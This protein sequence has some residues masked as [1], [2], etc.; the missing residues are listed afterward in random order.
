MWYCD[1]EQL[2]GWGCALFRMPNLEL[3]D[4]GGGREPFLRPEAG[5][6]A[7]DRE[8]QVVCLL[9]SHRLTRH[10]LSHTCTRATPTE[11]FARGKYFGISIDN[12]ADSAQLSM[13]LETIRDEVV[14]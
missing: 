11:P 8:T 12:R 10:H 3:A 2:G 4:G 7:G 1:D 6:R 5:Q 13:V 14:L 9:A